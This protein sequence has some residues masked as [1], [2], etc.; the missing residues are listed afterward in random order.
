M[1]GC[2]PSSIVEIDTKMVKNIIDIL[3][4]KFD[5]IHLSIQFPVAFEQLKG[6]DANFEMVTSNTI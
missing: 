3:M 6:S 4:N 5:K 1:W 2:R